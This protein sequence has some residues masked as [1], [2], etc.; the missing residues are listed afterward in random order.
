MHSRSFAT[1]DVAVAP[2]TIRKSA[3]I[4]PVASPEAKSVVR[5]R[6]SWSTP[7]PAAEPRQIDACLY[8]F[9]LCGSFR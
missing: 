9:G 7:H 5:S 8:M 3:A 6:G 4:S 2:R 1:A